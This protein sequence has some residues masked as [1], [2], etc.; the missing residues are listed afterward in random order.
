MS[1]LP[2]HVERSETTLS[3]PAGEEFKYE[4][5]FFPSYLKM[6]A[7]RED[8]PRPTSSWVRMTFMRQPEQRC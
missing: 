4:L 2:C 6:L 7:H 1:Q 8:F 5:R 3:I